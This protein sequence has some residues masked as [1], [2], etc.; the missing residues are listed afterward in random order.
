M[1]DDNVAPTP[2]SYIVYYF[3]DNIT[4]GS[5]TVEVIMATIT[6]PAMDS[7]VSVIVTAM[8]VFGSGSASNVILADISELY[9]YIYAYVYIRICVY[10]HTYMHT[11]MHTNN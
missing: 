5:A 3:G 9:M 7:D 11:R 2:V 10:I 4:N 8:N 1:Y 6:L